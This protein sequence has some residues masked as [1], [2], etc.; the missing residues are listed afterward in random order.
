MPNDLHKVR[1]PSIF[2]AILFFFRVMSMTVQAWV[3]NLILDVAVFRIWIQSYQE[4]RK[5][6]VSVF[7]S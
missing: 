2:D 7:G 5:L 4:E 1:L 6:V 3:V